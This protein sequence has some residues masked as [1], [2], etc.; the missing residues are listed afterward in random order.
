M[1]QPEVLLDNPAPILHP[2]RVQPVYRGDGRAGGPPRF[3]KEAL[4]FDLQQM[5]LVAILTLLV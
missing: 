5:R 3:F 1:F 2:L 4:R